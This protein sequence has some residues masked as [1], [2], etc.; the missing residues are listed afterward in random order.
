MKVKKVYEN[1]H[2][3]LYVTEN[4]LQT[5]I[6]LDNEKYN[7]V[8]VI[9]E[10]RE[11]IGKN[12]CLGLERSVFGSEALLL[13]NDVVEARDAHDRNNNECNED[14]CSKKGYSA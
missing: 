9:P 4:E 11:L 5:C 8:Q 13:H 12:G 2:V 10:I 1:D 3:I 6:V 14:Q 7:P